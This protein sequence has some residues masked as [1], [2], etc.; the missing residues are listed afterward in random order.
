MTEAKQLYKTTYQ[1]SYV[2]FPEFFVAS[3]HSF[4]NQKLAASLMANGKKSR[5]QCSWITLLPSQ[6]PILSHIL[7]LLI[8]TGQASSSNNSSSEE[9]KK[10]RS[11]A[12]TYPNKSPSPDSHQSFLERDRRRR[13]AEAKTLTSYPTAVYSNKNEYENPRVVDTDLKLS[14]S[15]LNQLNKLDSLSKKYSSLKQKEQEVSPSK[16]NRRMLKPKVSPYP[17][18]VIKWFIYWLIIVLLLPKVSMVEVVVVVM[19]VVLLLV[20]VLLPL[21]LPLPLPLLLHIFLTNNRDFLWHNVFALF[22][23]S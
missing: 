15:I 5:T 10:G 4:E 16:C 8:T 9:R 17:G 6:L 14:S 1:Q 19:V 7:T 22:P 20:L 21:P 2:D 12:H 13:R 11:R 23:R 3:G 18:R